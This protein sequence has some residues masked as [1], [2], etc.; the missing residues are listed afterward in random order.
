MKQSHVDESEAMIRAGS[1]D[2]IRHEESVTY[3]AKRETV[4]DRIDRRVARF[5]TE[6]LEHENAARYGH[7]RAMELRA[8]KGQLVPALGAQAERILTRMLDALEIVEGN[9]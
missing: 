6:A 3:N 2:Q 8:L 7:L 4:A 5:E 1:A 9:Q